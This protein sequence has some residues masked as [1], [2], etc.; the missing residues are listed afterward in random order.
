M[1]LDF[2]GTRHVE[3]AHLPTNFQTK[4]EPM[5]ALFKWKWL[6]LC[7]TGSLRP[8]PC[9]S[10]FFFVFFCVF[11]AAVYFLSKVKL[12]VFLFVKTR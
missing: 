4:D 7:I 10:V 8:Q 2:A 3:H 12:E 5:N 9:V 6:N 1:H 11:C